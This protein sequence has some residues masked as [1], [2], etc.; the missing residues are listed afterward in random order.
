MTPPKTQPDNPP[1][2]DEQKLDD[3]LATLNFS[4]LKAAI[5]KNTI[6]RYDNAL[7]TLAQ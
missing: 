5:V 7:R 4:P 6:A 1:I 3:L 2:Q